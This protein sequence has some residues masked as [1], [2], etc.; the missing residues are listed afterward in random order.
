[1]MAMAVWNSADTSAAATSGT[2]TP[3]CAPDTPP[4]MDFACRNCTNQAKV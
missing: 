1:M 2:F 4:S 3:I